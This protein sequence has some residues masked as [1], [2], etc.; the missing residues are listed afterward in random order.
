MSR[1]NMNGIHDPTV[2]LEPPDPPYPFLTTPPLAIA[3]VELSVSPP[4]ASP[5]PDLPV[6]SS[7]SVTPPPRN[8]L[9]SLP[10][11]K[12]K[13][14]LQDKVG[15][16]EDRI[17]LD[18]RDAE[19]WLALIKEHQSKGKITDTRNTYERFL[20]V[21]PDLVP[22]DGEV[23]AKLGIAV[24]EVCGYGVHGWGV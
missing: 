24:E 16:L 2:N 20:K 17:A 19:A 11:A 3:T 18:S 6:P 4:R 22:L 5:T 1:D 14:L 10:V 8:P 9:S 12:R 15:Q 23:E 13:R 21:F 7:A